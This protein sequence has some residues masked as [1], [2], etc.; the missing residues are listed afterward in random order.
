M[1]TT[2]AYVMLVC[3]TLF[4]AGNFM[5]GKFAFLTNIPPMSLVF[6]RWSLVWLILLPFT[7]KEIIKSKEIILNNL[8]LLLFL[9]FRLVAPDL[10]S[11][12]MDASNALIL[13]RRRW[14]SFKTCVRCTV[15]TCMVSLNC[16]VAPIVRRSTVSCPPPGA[17]LCL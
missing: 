12:E 2:K 10:R 8:P 9:A 1:Q 7:I 11:S 15:S 3:A 6:Y 5:I 14:F 17:S 16:L 4:W 13:S